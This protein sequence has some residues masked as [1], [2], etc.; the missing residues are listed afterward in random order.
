MTKPITFICEFRKFAIESSLPDVNG[1]RGVVGGGVNELAHPDVV[2]GLG[3][4]VG[5]G[6]SGV[7]SVAVGSFFFLSYVRPASGSASVS[8]SASASDS[9]GRGYTA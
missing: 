5:L 9:V 6:Q 8:D 1:V 7:H 2:R 4:G 3:V